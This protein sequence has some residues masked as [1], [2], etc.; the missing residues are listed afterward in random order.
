MK[1]MHS[2]LALQDP[3]RPQSAGGHFD[4]VMFNTLSLNALNSSLSRVASDDD[5]LRF[6][7]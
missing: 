6:M 4:H 7:D 5:G 3:A 2:Y 1:Y